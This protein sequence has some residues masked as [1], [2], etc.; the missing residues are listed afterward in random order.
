MICWFGFRKSIQPVKNESVDAGMELISAWSE[1]QMV[2]VCMVQLVPLPPF[3][4]LKSR[5]V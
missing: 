2:S 5:L 1:V 4:S 3:A